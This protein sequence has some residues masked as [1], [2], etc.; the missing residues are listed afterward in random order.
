M[1]RSHQ[2]R[3]RW[4]VIFPPSFS[5]IASVC[6]L[7]WEIYRSL[8]IINIFCEKHFILLGKEISFGIWAGLMITKNLWQ[9]SKV[10]SFI[11]VEIWGHYLFPFHVSILFFSDKLS[12]IVPYYFFWERVGM[13]EWGHNQYLLTPSLQV[14][15]SF[16]TWNK[17]ERQKA[18]CL[19]H[20]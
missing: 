9:I 4:S 8:G 20:L 2:C 14:N 10:S 15:G 6:L 19:M 11:K 16:F 1:L 12:I 3:K 18:I 5:L 13:G 17:E 7:L